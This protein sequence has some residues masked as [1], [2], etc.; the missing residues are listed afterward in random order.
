MIERAGGLLGRE[1][2]ELA[3]ELRRQLL[4][5]A[6]LGLIV[7][8]QARIAARLAGRRRRIRAD[9]AR[10]PHLLPRPVAVFT[11]AGN[12]RTCAVLRRGVLRRIAARAGRRQGIPLYGRGRPR[13]GVI[14]VT[15]RPAIRPRRRQ[16]ADVIIVIHDLTAAVDRRWRIAGRRHIAWWRVSGRWRIAGRRSI[17]GRRRRVILGAG[18]ARHPNHREQA[19]CDNA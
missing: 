18:G 2:D 16:R 12:G 9:I 17:S 13:R 4:G 7:R 5:L 1:V 3:S 19:R 15:S 8:R 11:A 10:G 14:L 6:D